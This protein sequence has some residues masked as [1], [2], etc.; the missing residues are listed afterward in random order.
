MSLFNNLAIFI[1]LVAVY[2]FLNSSLEKKNPIIRQ[3]ILGFTFAIFTIGCMNVKI[4]VAEGVIVD[5]RNAIV[6]ISGIFGGP[7]AAIIS[8]LLGGIYR[9]YLGGIG[10]L[11]GCVGLG[12][13]AIA[14]IV[15]KKMRVKID[16]V[17]KAA[18]G[19]MAATIPNINW[20]SPPCSMLG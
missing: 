16:T 8:A 1:I 11:G 9:A 13:A 19:A 20:F 3:I 10:V 18:I 2:G 14:G 5:Q 4:P 6:I 12:L 15:L 17:W 7:I